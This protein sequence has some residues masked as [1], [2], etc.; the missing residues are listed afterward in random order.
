MKLRGG[1]KHTLNRWELFY[2][3]FSV[4]IFF[5]YAVGISGWILDYPVWLIIP[6]FVIFLIPLLLLAKGSVVAIPWNIR[7]LYGASLLLLIRILYGVFLQRHFEGLPPLNKEERLAAMP[8]LVGISVFVV[9]WAYIWIRYF[10][11]RKSKI[12][13]EALG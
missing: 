13:R 8:I 11:R 5:F 1:R 10:S 4:P 7:V 2:L 6:I 12:Q 9:I 3:C